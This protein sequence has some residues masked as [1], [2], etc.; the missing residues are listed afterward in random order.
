MR[1]CIIGNSHIASL[2]S[3]WRSIAS[4]FGGVQPVF[5]G[6]P[7]RMM[8]DMKLKRGRLAAPRGTDLARQLGVTSGG[9]REIDGSY[10]VYV[11][12]G[13]ALSTKPLEAF[14]EGYRSIDYAVDGRR[15]L[16]RQCHREAVCALLDK[17]FLESLLHMLAGVTRAPVVLVAS[18]MRSE[19]DTSVFADVIA[20]GD[21]HALAASFAAGGY[22]VA[23]RHGAHFVPQ[24]S[25][26]LGR[27]PLTSARRF[28]IGSEKLRGPT[29][30]DDYIHMNGEYGALLL[31]AVL[32]C[33]IKA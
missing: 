3:G 29:R 11:L 15:L 30:E 21:D 33:L 12:Y 31:R 19:R 8:V 14:C 9:L 32:S 13:A 16:S 4:E 24:P 17:G 22:E 25:E 10:D 20:N 27:S 18:P 5:F 7:M 2:Q 6:A 26:T 1:L 23:R 28:S